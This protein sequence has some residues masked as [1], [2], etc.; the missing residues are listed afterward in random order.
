MAPAL[1][2]GLRST[3]P[4]SAAMAPK[5]RQITNGCSE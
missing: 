3:M 2:M 5:M 1:F 4:N